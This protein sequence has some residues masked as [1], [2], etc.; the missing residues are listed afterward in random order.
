MVS[1]NQNSVRCLIR[2]EWVQATP[3]E[4]V[5]QKLLQKMLDEWGYPH[6]LLLVEKSLSQ[7]P[8]IKQAQKVPNRRM[9]IVAY[10]KNSKNELV[11]LLLIECKATSRAPT[12]AAIRQLLGYNYYIGAPFVGMACGA[13]PLQVFSATTSLQILE[14]PA[15]KELQ[16]LQYQV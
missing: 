11:P 16:A 6:S 7:L 13:Y 1:L 12:G 14:V 4:R 9:D 5:R 15:Y 8:H 3:E 2:Q 10:G